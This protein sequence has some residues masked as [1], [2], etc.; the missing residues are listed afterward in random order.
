MR[1]LRS[2]FIIWDQVGGGSYIMIS[3][4][5]GVY[6]KKEGFRDRKEA[7]DWLER[8]L[9]KNRLE[10]LEETVFAGPWLSKGLRP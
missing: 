10:K 9:R 2:Q 1:E 4:G 7:E 5:A 8:R 6:E 3:H